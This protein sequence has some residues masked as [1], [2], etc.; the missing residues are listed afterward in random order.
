MS[1]SQSEPSPGIRHW[2]GPACPQH[3]KPQNVSSLKPP[4]FH[5]QAR[6]C[7]QVG[8]HT[9]GATRC[10]CRF[11]LCVSLQAPSNLLRCL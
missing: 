9:G 8:A 1:L 6:N 11:D 10:K 4:G 2:C 7:Q 3:T 5:H